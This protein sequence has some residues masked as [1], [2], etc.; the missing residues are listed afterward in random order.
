M[1]ALLLAVLVARDE[2][3]DLVER[4]RAADEKDQA[5]LAV[6]LPALAKPDHLPQL[7]Q[8]TE[9]GPEALRPYFL[10]AIG[11]VGNDA[12]RSA[13]Q[14]FTQR[15]NLETRAEAAGQLRMLQDPEGPKAAV[16]LL[17]HAQTNPEKTA[18]LRQLG[19]GTPIDCPD[20]VPALARFLEKETGEEL[21]RLAIRTIGTYKDEAVL[22]PLRTAAKA[23]ADPARFLAIAELVRRGDEPA[24]NDALKGLEDQ[25]V[26][27]DS[28]N[29]LVSAI[30][31]ANRPAALPRLRA[32]LEK[33][34]DR[35]LKIALLRA[36]ATLK[37]ESSAALM[38]K[39]S[40][41]ADPAVAKVAAESIVRLG[42]QQKAETIRKAAAP[43][44]TDSD[45]L[46]KLDAVETL[47]QSDSPEGWAAL[48]AALQGGS[49]AVRARALF[50]LYPLRRREA[51]DLLV[52]L[53]EDPSENNRSLAKTAIVSTL[54]ALYP[55]QKFSYEVPAD[56][57]KLWWEKN[58]GR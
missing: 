29:P 19:G 7:V 41:D 49:A 15:F 28:L 47:L 52:P 38:T 25:K 11:R 33:T 42:L 55:Y 44:N 36:L 1:I 6:Q 46:R 31:Q 10:R 17:P 8:E 50:I 16:R 27:R 20:A 45:A 35:D 48:R 30:E 5:R 4:I 14:E 53:L 56:K 23:S 18:V 34:G 51:L 2:L 12:A 24:L 26:D 32:L 58:R 57:L 54:T 43:V 21:R 13:L 37:D 22:A 3:T 39:L 40:T 9:D